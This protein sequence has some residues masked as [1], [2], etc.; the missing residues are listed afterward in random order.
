MTWEWLQGQLID[1]FGRSTG[2]LAQKAEWLA[3]TMG[4]KNSDGSESGGKSTYT[5]KAYTT[6]FT[7]LMRALTT[8]TPLT[9]DLATID[10]Y[11][12]GI[13]IGCPAIWAEMKGMHAVLSYDTLSEAISAAQVAESALSARDIQHSSIRTAT[14]DQVYHQLIPF[15]SSPSYIPPH[16]RL[17]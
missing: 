5:V 16:P 7:R 11:N 15:R 8:H 1:D 2:V 6:H 4:I 17:L 13:R 12:E 10:R 9:D 14:S 3:L